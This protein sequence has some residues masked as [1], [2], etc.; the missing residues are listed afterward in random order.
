MDP[1][2]ASE[3]VERYVLANGVNIQTRMWKSQ[4]PIDP[5]GGSSPN[6][7]LAIVAHP[8][9]FLGGSWNDHVVANISR[10]LLNTG[11]HVV[12][13]NSRGIGKSTGWPSLTY[14]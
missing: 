12:Q 1:L 14:S 5:I 8:L 7:K 9:G 2:E 6:V 11:W 13:F 4:S 3:P 10:Y